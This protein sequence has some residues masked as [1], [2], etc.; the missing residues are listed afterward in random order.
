ML[1]ASTITYAVNG[2]QYVAVFT[3]EG[4]SGTNNVLA[5]RPEAEARAWPHCESRAPLTILLLCWRAAGQF[6][7]RFE[8]AV[9]AR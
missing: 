3:G 4:Q 5:K 2:K 1:I 8:G 6:G 7:R 9:I